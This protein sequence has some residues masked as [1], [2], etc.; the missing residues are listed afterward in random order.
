MS[1]T[2]IIAAVLMTCALAAYSA[3]VWAERSARYLR[4]WHVAA[5]WAGLALD[6][7][8]TYAMDLLSTSVEP[9]PFHL[10]TGIAAFC[11][12]AAHAVWA[13][14]V[15]V[16]GGK[17]ARERFHRLSVAVWLLWLVPYLGGLVFGLTA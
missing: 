6:A 15:L 1:P 7:A 2:L 9:Q 11:V 14:A 13:L 3:G 8:G 17:R 4:P 12:M 5:F 10:V 16:W